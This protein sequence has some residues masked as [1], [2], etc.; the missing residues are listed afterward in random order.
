MGECPQNCVFPS[1]EGSKKFYSNGSK[2]N[3]SALGHSFDWLV[4]RCVGISIIC[5]DSSQTG[6]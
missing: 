4:M 5:S 2:S 3:G 6:V 1:E